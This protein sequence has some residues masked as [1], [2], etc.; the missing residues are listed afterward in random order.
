MSD[1]VK[2]H[3]LEFVA[4]PATVR[5]EWVHALFRDDNGIVSLVEIMK[6]G[7]RGNAVK[8]LVEGIEKIR[9]V[10]I[11]REEDIPD[12]LG[13]V[14]ENIRVEL[15]LACA[16]SALRTAVTQ[17][18]SE[19]RGISLTQ[20]LG[21]ELCES[22]P[23]YA[24]INRS[25]LGNRSPGAFAHAAELAVR[26][27]FNVI[28]CAPFDEVA[29]KDSNADKLKCAEAGIQ[30]VSEIKRTVGNDITLFVDCHQ[31]FDEKA[32]LIIF[33]K[34]A[35]IGIGWFEEPVPEGNNQSMA[36]ILKAISVPLAG[37]E[38]GYGMSQFLELISSSACDIVM[39]DIK[40]C[41]GVAEAQ[42]VGQ[43]IIA[44]GAKYSPHCPSGPVSLLAS[45]HATAAVK[46]AYLLEHAVNEI[47]WRA[48]I[49]SPS[50]RIEK[51]RL[52]FP[53]ES[54]LGATLNT[55]MVEKKGRCWTP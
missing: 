45:A 30:R 42:R 10:S 20:A 34:L 18:Q 5:T 13:L 48:D 39:P 41:G 50:E 33:E 25:L 4:F 46:G 28:K 21:G 32:A 27:G 1:S 12:L 17:F 26:S 37:G 19:Y 44:A 14:D 3:S 53:G 23:L 22:I 52:W 9:G 40:F 49:L 24:N 8:Y 16:V 6:T 2:F 55:N 36:R 35:E 29:I 15:D 38:C 11:K 7:S 31:R 47:L 54:G 43:S 51:G